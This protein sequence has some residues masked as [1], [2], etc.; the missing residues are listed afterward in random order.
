MIWLWSK[1]NEKNDHPPIIH[2]LLFRLVRVAEFTGAVLCKAG[3]GEKVTE[4]PRCG[5]RQK[6]RKLCPDCKKIRRQEAQ[7]R[8]RMKRRGKRK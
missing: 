1:R 2:P 7:A 3:D 6:Q 5:K 8:Y 4:C